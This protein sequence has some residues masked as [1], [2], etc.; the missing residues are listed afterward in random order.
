MR[1]DAPTPVHV[2]I[3][4][5]KFIREEINEKFMRDELMNGDLDI[6]TNFAK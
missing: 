6:A 3:V 4:N 2:E 1:S 5:D